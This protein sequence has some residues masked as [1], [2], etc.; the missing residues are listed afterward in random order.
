M[1]YKALSII[2]GPLL[3]CDLIDEYGIKHGETQAT[4]APA[5]VSPRKNPNHDTIKGIGRSLQQSKNASEKLKVA[6][7]VAE[8]LITHWRD[9]VRQMKSIGVM[10]PTL[11][12]HRL[13]YEDDTVTRPRLRTSAS[14][15]LFIRKSQN[16]VADETPVRRENRSRSPDFPN[17]EY[18]RY[19]S[20][21]VD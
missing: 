2:F 14:E 1:G 16:L 13:G 3:L 18:P 21:I 5:K 20:D 9:I 12:R 11:A 10:R 15:S 7:R 17:S 8:M 6:N 4:A 19:V